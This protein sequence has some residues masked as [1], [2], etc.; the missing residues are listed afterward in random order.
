MQASEMTF[1]L[2]IEGISLFD[3]VRVAL[4]FENFLKHR[5]AASSN[6]KI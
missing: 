2:M 1:L 5:A 6:R 3:K 4:K